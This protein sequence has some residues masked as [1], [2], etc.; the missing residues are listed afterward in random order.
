MLVLERCTKAFKDSQTYKN[1]IRYLKKWIQFVSAIIHVSFSVFTR[2]SLCQADLC[3]DPKD[4]FTYLKANNIGLCFS[5]FWEAW[6][7]V[8]EMKGRPIRGNVPRRA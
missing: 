3:A 5:L 2:I 4:V 6:A 7:V 1:D 8:L